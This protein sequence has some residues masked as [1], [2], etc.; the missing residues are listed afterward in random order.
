MRI[1]SSCL[2]LVVLATAAFAAAQDYRIEEVRSLTATPINQLKLKTIA[3][4]ELKG[5]EAGD[6]PVALMRFEDWG[7][8]R[9]VQKQFLSL[10]PDYAER[11]V[12]VT[13][14][15]TAK[16]VKERMHVYVAEARFMVARPAASVPLARYASVQFL[17]RID[18]AIKHQVIAPADAMPRKNA[19]AAHNRNPERAWCEGMAPGICIQSRY[20]F[21]GKLPAGIQLANKLREQ[22]RKPIVDFIEFQ[23]ELRV[24]SADEIKAIETAKLTGVDAP[25]QAALVQNIFWVNQIMQFGKLLAI[26]QQH[27]TDPG[28]DNRFRLYRARG[29]DRRAREAEGLRER[30]GTAQLGAPAGAARQQLFQHRQ[31]DQ[32]R[33]AE[34]R[35][36]PRAGD[37][38]HHRAGIALTERVVARLRRASSPRRRGPRNTERMNETRPLHP[39]RG[40]E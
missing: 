23:S 5:D 13:T 2:A 24:M 35:A 12:Q 28:Q 1:G 36:Q 8:V 4:S 30:A 7:R 27:P 14:N 33:T 17:E 32:R 34:I 3:F 18:P 11:T 25:V 19:E 31:L 29:E 16:P 38:R 22:G 40:L 15:G 10:Y 39:A 21:E 6:A 9:P 26:V 20:R 37:R